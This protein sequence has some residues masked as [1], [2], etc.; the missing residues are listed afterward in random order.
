[1][2]SLK[3]AIELNKII[4]ETSGGSNGLRDESLLLSALNRPVQNFD[5]KE[6]YS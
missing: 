3:L 5:N 4:S 6:L 2:I 1:M